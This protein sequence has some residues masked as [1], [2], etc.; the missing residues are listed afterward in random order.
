MRYAKFIG[1]FL[2]LAPPRVA[3]STDIDAFSLHSKLPQ[4]LASWIEQPESSFSGT[5][6]DQTIL[7]EIGTNGL[8]LPGCTSS[9]C[10]VKLFSTND[11]GHDAATIRYNKN[12]IVSIQWTFVVAQQEHYL[13]STALLHV[14]FLAANPTRRT[15]KAMHVIWEAAGA[16]IR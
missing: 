12:G 3:L 8:D 9:E 5:L 15:R 7:S 14:L 6:I 13:G 4:P 1:I 10:T 2:A 16:I 11:I